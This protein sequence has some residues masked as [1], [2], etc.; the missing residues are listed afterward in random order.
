M[1]VPNMPVPPIPSLCLLIPGCK[2][3]VELD[4]LMRLIMKYHMQ[5]IGHNVFCLREET[6][7]VGILQWG[8]D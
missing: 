3:T 8:W 4:E 1:C 5:C 7:A 6:C 2:I